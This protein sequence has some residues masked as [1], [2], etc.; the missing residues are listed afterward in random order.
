MTVLIKTI[1]V[2][3]D[4]IEMM[5]FFW[6][7]IAEKEKVSEAYMRDIAEKEEMEYLYGPEFNK[8]SV[9][10]VLSAISNRELLSESTKKERKFWNNNMWILEDLGNMNNM[11][12]PV[13]TLNLDDLKGKFN[14]ETKFDDITVIFIPG[15]EDEYYIDENR[16]VIN[17]FRLMVDF[18]DETKVNISGK[19]MKEYIEEK[20]LEILK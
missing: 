5:L 2:N 7:S 15:H 20:I 16:L 13:K 9:R 19:P 18:M 8:E 6:Q 1:K 14:G 12:M 17:F 3:Y 11:I 10:K 4:T